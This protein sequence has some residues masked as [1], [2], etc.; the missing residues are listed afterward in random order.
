[1]ARQVGTGHVLELALIASPQRQ[2]D[3][4]Q[5]VLAGR[6]KAGEGRA[7]QLFQGRRRQ[8]E[9]RELIFHVR[10]LAGGPLRIGGGQQ[11][12]I[13]PGEQRC[14]Q[15]RHRPDPATVV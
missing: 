2:R 8:A 1:M 4:P 6:R 7:L 9:K 14:G 12:L 13:E 5:I 3:R 15:V 10:R 11:D